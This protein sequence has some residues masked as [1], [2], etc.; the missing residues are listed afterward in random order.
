[1]PLGVWLGHIHRGSFL[2]INVANIGRALPSLAVIAIGDRA[3][4][5]S[6]FIN[7][8]LALVVLAAPPILTNAYVGVDGVDRDARRR[9]ARHGH[10]RARGAVAGRAAARAA[11]DLRRHPHGRGLRVATA[12]LGALAGT[13]AGSATSSPTRRAT[14]S[15][16]SSARRSASPRSRSSV[17]GAASRCS[18]ASL[19]PRGLRAQMRLRRRADG[20]GGTSHESQ[21]TP[22]QSQRQ[23][24]PRLDPEPW[25]ALLA[26][27]LAHR[28]SRRA[29]AAATRARRRARA[30]ASTSARRGSPARASRRSR[31]AT[32]TSP[33]ST[34]SASSTRRR[35]E[36]RASR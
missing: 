9:R 35:C 30:R 12:P 17:D 16:A 15:R 18:S 8:M 21:A 31:S 23:G 34:S 7:V 32:R 1:M 22:D 14:S 5:A 36:R 6:A 24:A 10:A 3:R 20:G 13:A 11:A 19:T 28:P 27:A 29:A 25:L 33:R 2:A 26:V 4:S